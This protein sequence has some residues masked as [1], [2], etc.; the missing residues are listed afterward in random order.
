MVTIFWQGHSKTTLHR[1]WGSRPRHVYR[2]SVRK[3]LYLLRIRG[4]KTRSIRSYSQPPPKPVCFRCSSPN[5]CTWVNCSYRHIC[6]ACHA[7]DHKDSDCP[8]IK[9]TYKSDK[10]PFVPRRE[11]FPP[12]QSDKTHSSCTYSQVDTLAQPQLN[13]PGQPLQLDTTTVNTHTKAS[14]PLNQPSPH[15]V[16][17]WPNYSPHTTLS[18]NS[19]PH[20]GNLRGDSLTTHSGHRYVFNQ[21]KPDKGTHSSLYVQSITLSMPRQIVTQASQHPPYKVATQTQDKLF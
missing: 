8:S 12:P 11:N 9:Q 7:K 16:T 3:S 20:D 1:L 14:P 18:T 15:L 13:A 2:Q 10:R 4:N 17:T 19:I 5:G 6:R 21:S